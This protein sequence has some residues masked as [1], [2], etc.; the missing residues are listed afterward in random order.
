MKPVAGRTLLFPGLTMHGITVTESTESRPDALADVPGICDL[1]LT[2][3]VVQYRDVHE[4][5]HPG[6][7]IRDIGLALVLSGRFASSSRVVDLGSGEVKYLNLTSEL[8][9]LDWVHEPTLAHL[10]LLS[11]TAETT[12]SRAVQLRRYCFDLALRV[13]NRRGFSP[14]TRPILLRIGF[15]DLCRDL[16]LHEST[17]VRIVTGPDATTR[18]HLDYEANSLVFRTHGIGSAEGLDRSLQS[19]FGGLPVERWRQGA[20][21]RYGTRQVRLGVP[22]NF[23]EVLKSL[24]AMRRGLGSLVARY[25]PERF[26][27]VNGLMSTFGERATLERLEFRD[28]G[29]GAVAAG[30]DDMTT[31]VH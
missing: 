2:R 16:D 5:H 4:L 11:E 14:L 26:G 1:P 27:M 7:Q 31:A 21:E 9:I 18:V 12:P 22:V 23:D 25:E 8:V 29:F 10:R 20:R 6:G 17:V 24:R 3:A 28:D 19:A 15:R 13:L 30:F